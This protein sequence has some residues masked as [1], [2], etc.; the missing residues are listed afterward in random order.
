MLHS[1]VLYNGFTK[2]S[3]DLV[4]F[5]VN[6]TKKLLFQK[7]QKY[8]RRDSHS[9]PDRVLTFLRPLR[10]ILDGFTTA[11]RAT[12]L[13]E[14]ARGPGAG[15]HASRNEKSR[16]R[17]ISKKHEKV[18]EMMQNHEKIMK[19]EDL[20]GLVSIWMRDCLRRGLAPSQTVV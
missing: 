16:P 9:F 19:I 3:V 4:G 20:V 14:K 12:R 5:I 6:N 1:R 13:S 15:S 8:R 17:K 18:G 2:L 7:V 11:Q 10:L